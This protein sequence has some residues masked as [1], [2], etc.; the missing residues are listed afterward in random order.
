MVDPT[1]QQLII[2]MHAVTLA[3]HEFIHCLDA[4]RS[5]LGQQG[6]DPVDVDAAIMVWADY[7]AQKASRSKQLHAA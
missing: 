5:H 4:L 3:R 2:L 6:Y 1:E 7:E